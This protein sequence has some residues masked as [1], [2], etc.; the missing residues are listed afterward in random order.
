M[1]GSGIEALIGPPQRHIWLGIAAAWLALAGCTVEAPWA[2]KGGADQPCFADSTCLDG[3]FCVA[4]TCSSSSVDGGLGDLPT[5]PDVIPHPDFPCP[6]PPAPPRLM[7]YPS[8]TV[9]N[10]VALRGTAVGAAKVMVV[11]GS[12]SV[13]SATVTGGAF[14]TVVFLQNLPTPQTLYLVAVD[15]KGC[16]SAPAHAQ[17]TYAPGQALNLLYSKGV[18]SNKDPVDGKASYLTDGNVQQVVTYKAPTTMWYCDKAAYNYLWFDLGVLSK[19][20]QVVIKYP[21][22]KTFR[23]YLACWT[24]LA[25]KLDAPKIPRGKGFAPDWVAVYTHSK[26]KSTGIKL[27]LGGAQLRHLAVMM[28]EDGQF[29]GNPERFDFTEIEV[30]GEP[31][32]PA[33]P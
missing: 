2:G 7:P 11:G 4:G 15:H 17:V 5:M 1:T 27:D 19:V 25:S 14:C 24:L 16:L 28:F 20:K 21:D 30:W 10:R 31:S 6:A 3:L 32:P 8:S 12:K 13:A 22:S 26:D 9:Q 23:G 33:C 29:Y 18:Q